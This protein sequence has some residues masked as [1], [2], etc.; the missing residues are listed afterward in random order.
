MGISRFG[1]HSRIL[2]ALPIR[3]W[4]NR[5]TNAVSNKAFFLFLSAQLILTILEES[6]H[7]S[8]VFLFQFSIHF[9][10]IFTLLCRSLDPMGLLIRARNRETVRGQLFGNETSSFLAGGSECISGSLSVPFRGRIDQKDVKEMDWAEQLYL[11]RIGGH[12]WMT[13]CPTLPTEKCIFLPSSQNMSGILIRTYIFSLKGALRSLKSQACWKVR[14][15]SVFQITAWF[16]VQWKT[17]RWAKR[18]ARLMRDHV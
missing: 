11:I 7:A 17:S 2:T 10:G 3:E 4:M 16:Y 12:E 15:W 5:G 8:S 6:E 9:L 1:S 18:F 13:F 14:T